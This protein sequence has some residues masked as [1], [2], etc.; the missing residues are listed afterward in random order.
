MFYFCPSCVILLFMKADSVQREATDLK[1]GDS[2]ARVVVF[3]FT[4]LGRW[5]IVG[6]KEIRLISLDS[7]RGDSSRE[8]AHPKSVQD[9]C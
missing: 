1:N 6:M 8:S 9:R 7:R 3:L 2:F 4:E 5:W